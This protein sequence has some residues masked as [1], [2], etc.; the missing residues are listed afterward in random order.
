MMPWNWF[1]ALLSALPPNGKLIQGRNLAKSRQMPRVHITYWTVH[2][3]LFLIGLPPRPRIKFKVVLFHMW[4]PQYQEVSGNELFIT[5]CIEALYMYLCE[6]FFSFAG[7]KLRSVLRM[8]YML[9]QGR[10]GERH[11]CD[12]P[13]HGSTKNIKALRM[14]SMEVPFP[15]PT[16]RLIDAKEFLFGFGFRRFYPSIGGV[17][18]VRDRCS[19]HLCTTNISLQ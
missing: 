9:C 18:G 6:Y 10:A 5:R 17:F 19:L 4:N 13:S 7:W 1:N 16:D 15:I 8:L 12:R 3:P 14:S 2:S 11:N